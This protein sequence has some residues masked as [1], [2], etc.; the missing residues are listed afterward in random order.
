MSESEVRS[1][2]SDGSGASFGTNET[3]GTVSSECDTLGRAEPL[4][5]LGAEGE[6]SCE[7]GAACAVYTE[8]AISGQVSHIFTLSL[9]PRARARA[10]RCV[11]SG[12]K[13]AC[14]YDP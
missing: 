9:D 7:H 3:R 14:S 5:S 11:V 1:C 6:S 10:L 2:R 8:R 13:T 4:A 12:K